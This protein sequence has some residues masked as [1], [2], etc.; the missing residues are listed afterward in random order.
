VTEGA[1][2]PQGTTLRYYKLPKVIQTVIL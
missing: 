1:V 2:E